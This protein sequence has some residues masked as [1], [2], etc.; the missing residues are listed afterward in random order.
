MKSRGFSEA[1]AFAL[2][3]KK[4]MDM[5]KPMAEIADAIVLTEKMTKDKT[6]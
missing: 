2:I 4:S 1:E 6:A 3:Q 5:R